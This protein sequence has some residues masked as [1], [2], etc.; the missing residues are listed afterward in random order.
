MVYIAVGEKGKFLNQIIEIANILL[1]CFALLFFIITSVPFCIAG[2]DGNNHP[3]K[4]PAQGYNLEMTSAVSFV[5]TV[6]IPSFRKESY[7]GNSSEGSEAHSNL[8]AI[9]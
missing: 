2:N 7:G 8:A 4:F 5:C 6:I 3:N 9:I 1:S